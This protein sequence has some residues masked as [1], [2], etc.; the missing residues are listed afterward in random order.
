MSGVEL[1]LSMSLKIKSH[2]TARL[3]INDFILMF[4]SSICP[5]F[6]LGYK[7]LSDFELGVLLLYQVKFNSAVGNQ[8][9]PI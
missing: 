8:S 1:D 3:P 7:C 6:V 4:N 5:N 9:V 2:G